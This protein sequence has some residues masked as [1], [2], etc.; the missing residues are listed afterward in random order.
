MKIVVLGSHGTGKTTL[1][2]RLLGY[3]RDNYQFTI[4]KVGRVESLKTTPLQN[5]FG[6]YN[7][8]YLP[9]TP[10]E[11]TQHGFTMN[12]DT[13]LESEFWMIGKQLELELQSA[14][15]IADKCLIDMLAYAR[16]FFQNEP[17]FLA[18]IERICKRN[19]N[20]DVVFY[21][22]I[23]EFSIE[24]DGLRS[25]DPGFQRDIDRLIRDIF[26][27]LNIPY[28]T[29]RGNRDARFEAAKAIIDENIN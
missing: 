26:L 24:D 10:F 9:E 15:W 18:V 17:E 29:L 22:P 13:S 14:P 19:I 6:R 7:W 28:Y 2:K 4:E 8:R 20:Y 11:A 23:G 16:Y 1:S 5:T 21:L 27:E 12:Q 25:L 3:L